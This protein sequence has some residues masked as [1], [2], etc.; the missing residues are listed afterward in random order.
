MKINTN[1]LPKQ[2]I[3][4]IRRNY[5][6]W[7]ANQTLEDF[8]LRFTAKSARKRP[9]TV[10]I[11]ALGSAGFLVQEAIGGQATLQY[12]FTNTLIACLVVF[13]LL[14][15]LSIPICRTA[16]RAGLDI[17]LLT[18]GAGFGYLGSTLT[19]LIYATFTFIFFALE[20]TVMAQALDWFLHVPVWMGY[21]LCSLIVLPIVSHGITYISRF[22]VITLPIWVSL[23]LLPFLCIY[24]HDSHAWS[25]WTSYH[26]PGHSSGFNLVQ[27]GAI[28]TVLFALIGQTCEQVDYL[29]FLPVK[30]PVRTGRQHVYT[31]SPMKK[32]NDEHTP[33]LVTPFFSSSGDTDSS[34]QQTK[35]QG[36]FPVRM[37]WS[38]NGALLAGGAGWTLIGLCK[39]LAGSFLAVLAVDSGLDVLRAAEPLHMYLVGFSYVPFKGILLTA[40]TCLFIVL[41]QLRINVTNAYAG[42]LAWSNFFSRLTHIHPGRV[43]WLV[44]NLLIALLLM[45]VG[46]YRAFTLI[47]GSYSIIAIGWMGSVVA[48]ICINKPLG[49]CPEKI[50]FRRGYLFDINPVGIGS[51]AIAVL[52][53]LLAYLDFL[54]STAQ[55]L[56][57]YLTLLTTLVTVPLLA[58]WTKGRYHHARPVDHIVEGRQHACCICGHAF[59]AEDMSFCPAY[60]SQICSLCCSLDARCGGMCKENAS[61]AEQLTSWLK[62]ILPTPWYPA[63]NSRMAHFVGLFGSV[64]CLITGM[65]TLIYRQL[66]GEGLQPA[67]I[68][69]VFLQI[70]TM[71]MILLGV[72]CW[73]V[74]LAHESKKLAREESHRQTAML[75]EEVEA[76][77]KT[78]HALQKAKEKAE[79][80]S[81]AKSRYLTGLSHELRSPLN[82]AYG[83]AQLLEI[84]RSIP[85][86]KRPAI[87]AIRRNTA[88]LSQLIE[89][90]LDI[91]RIEAGRIELKRGHC[92]I[93]EIMGDLCLMAQSMAQQKGVVFEVTGEKT[94]PEWVTTDEKRLRQILTNL[95]SNAVKFT[96][97][98]KVSLSISYQNQIARFSIRDTGVGIAADDLNRIFQP[99]ERI[100]TPGQPSVEGLGMGL[101]I[102]RLLA[103]VMG[104]ELVAS[105]QP[106]QGSHFQLS[107]MLSRVQSQ[108]ITPATTPWVVGYKGARKTIMVVDDDAGHRQLMQDVLS[109]LGF[110][111]RTSADGMDCLHQLQQVLP[112]TPE[113]VL[114][115]V[116]MP[117]MTG[118]E[119]AEALRQQQYSGTIVMLSASADTQESMDIPRDFHDDYILK[120]FVMEEL[121]HTF[122]QHL[123]LEWVHEQPDFRYVKTSPSLSTPGMAAHAIKTDVQ[124]D[125]NAADVL[126]KRTH[127]E[128]SYSLDQWRDETLALAEVGHL[129]GLRQQLKKAHSDERFD[130]MQLKAL[131]MALARLDF[132]DIIRLL[133][134]QL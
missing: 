65:M 73:L 4:P 51:M 131:D 66:P 110:N 5:N 40:F 119:T 111:V 126:D 123:A 74:V 124:D 94:L 80:A 37:G 41:C 108:A 100:L 130:A 18:R 61:A 1:R 6:Q 96:N 104:G 12:G 10:A 93:R 107:L 21:I 67:A 88:H 8:S 14:F 26:S 17:D 43:V 89:E 101:T 7:V 48:D 50:E 109:S 78:D 85:E 86:D 54:G 72:I 70:Y 81:R 71:L 64:M 47:L 31:V 76:H 69:P 106:G 59:D 9:S 57:C 30:R 38:W 105:S 11:T 97:Q 82:A 28:S 58:W 22:Q 49:L 91:S 125:N 46:M 24:Y 33:T 87:S 112:S 60:Y 129:S 120:P 3:F 42:S 115:D 68:L 25:Q 75:M 20:S 121:L 116:G 103:E 27:F 62:R 29:R 122:A 127:H 90:L 2:R 118:W 34:T 92:R 45:E 117:G 23:Q 55:A 114:M 63:L 99:F 134:K 15:L 83:Y 44:F 32:V 56:A 53:G 16:A 79:T 133:E 84:D 19:S 98:G 128:S 113:L 132:R 36:K 39:T 95:L 102:S 13:A 77:E 52:L 35:R